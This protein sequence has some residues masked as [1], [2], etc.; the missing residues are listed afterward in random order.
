MG[1]GQ[2]SG[3]AQAAD[4]QVSAAATIDRLGGLPGREQVAVAV[5][6][7]EHAHE[8]IV[9]EPPECLAE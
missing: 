3:Q 9:A 7:H 6:G 8:V 5:R 4:R 2:L 1:C